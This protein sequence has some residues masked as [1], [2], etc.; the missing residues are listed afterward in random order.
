MST[1][2]PILDSIFSED[3]GLKDIVDDSTITAEMASA[4]LGKLGHPVSASTIRT[5]RRSRKPKVA[6]VAQSALADSA[7]LKSVKILTMDIETI[8][9][10]VWTYDLKTSWIPHKHITQPGDMLCWAAKWYHQPNDTLF[11]GRNKGYDEMLV[12]L[13]TLLEEADYMVGWNSD[14]FDLQ[15]TRG[16]F[17]RAGLPPFVP[18]KSIDLMR[19]AKT[20]GYESASLDYTARQFGVTRKVDNGGA[21]NWE[22][23]M[24]GDQKSWDLMEEY[25]RGDIITTEELFDAMR[26]WIKGHPNIHPEPGF[27]PRCASVDLTY[28]GEFQAEAYRYAMYRCGN[29]QG[30]SRETARTRASILRAV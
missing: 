21:T 20:F 16:Y 24:A 6:P 28:A 25:N 23:C 9:A 19:T 10:H 27:C 15:K 30:L 17:A 13:W 1:G 26:P 22:G 11:A 18:P 3:P 7:G 8:P 5:Y 2:F 14:R 12:Q 29:C 4:G